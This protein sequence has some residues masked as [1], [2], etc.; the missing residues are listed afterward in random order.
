M[1][2]IFCVVLRVWL[3]IWEMIYSRIGKEK[4]KY[5]DENESMKC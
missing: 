4:A 1:A 3:I 5:I 2:T